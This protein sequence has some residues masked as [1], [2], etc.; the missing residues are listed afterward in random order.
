MNKIIFSSFI[1]LLITTS[2]FSDFLL[3]SDNH[4]IYDI[5]PYQDNSGYCYTA[6]S[7]GVTYCNKSLTYN[8]F[9]DGYYVV[10]GDC[11]MKNDLLITGLTQNQWNYLLAVL[12]HVLGFTMLFLIN[13]LSIL[14]SKGRS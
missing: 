5:T 9:I 7:T 12:A 11:V 1:F 3:R 4:C 2:S 8:D 14:V 6:R 10:D 13:Y